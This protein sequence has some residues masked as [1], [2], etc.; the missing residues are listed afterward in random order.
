MSYTILGALVL[1]GLLASA[2]VTG[3]VR[4]GIRSD[5]GYILPMIRRSDMSHSICLHH[6]IEVTRNVWISLYA[7]THR[8]GSWISVIQQNAGDHTRRYSDKQE[9][10]VVATRPVVS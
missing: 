10:N 4:H 1:Y 6:D 2:V 8:L 9:I 5:D 7:E 3:P